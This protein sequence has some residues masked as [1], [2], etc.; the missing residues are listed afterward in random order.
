MRL[1]Y[2]HK[3]REKKKKNEWKISATC[4]ASIVQCEGNAYAYI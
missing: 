1:R 4:A 3:R 2:E